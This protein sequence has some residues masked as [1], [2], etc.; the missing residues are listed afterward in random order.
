VVFGYENSIIPL[1]PL[2]YDMGLLQWIFFAELSV[3]GLGNVG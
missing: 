3:N 2:L 1:F